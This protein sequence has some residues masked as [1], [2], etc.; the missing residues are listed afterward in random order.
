LEKKEALGR[1]GGSDSEVN[2][3]INYIMV[4]VFQ[5]VIFFGTGL[6][7]TKHAVGVIN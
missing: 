6:N 4:E 1:L 3:A 7:L 5:Q 2:T